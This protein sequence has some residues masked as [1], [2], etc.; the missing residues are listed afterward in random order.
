MNEIEATIT[1]TTG[2]I[3]EGLFKDWN[4]LSS[5]LAKDWAVILHVSAHPVRRKDDSDEH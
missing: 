4:D 1:Y 3:T 5:Y 2:L